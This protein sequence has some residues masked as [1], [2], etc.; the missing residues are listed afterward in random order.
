VG[1]GTGAHRRCGP[2]I[3][4]EEYGIDLLTELR[5]VTAVLFVLWIG[6]GE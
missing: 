1:G 6:D 4:V 3:P 2:A 5:W